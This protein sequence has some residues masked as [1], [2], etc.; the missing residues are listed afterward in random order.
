MTATFFAPGA[1]PVFFI[2]THWASSG[3][4]EKTPRP[5]ALCFLSI[6]FSGRFK[7]SKKRDYSAWRRRVVVARFW[8]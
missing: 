2:A 6:I 7:Y 5:H 4:E 8:Q 3:S 1:W